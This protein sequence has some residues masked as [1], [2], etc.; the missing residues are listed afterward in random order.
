MNGRIPVLLFE[1]YKGENEKERE[2]RTVIEKA[3][4]NFFCVL[5]VN[6]IRRTCNDKR[7]LLIEEWRNQN[8]YEKIKYQNQI[9]EFIYKIGL[10]E[11]CAPFNLVIPD[12]ITIKL[13]DTGNK[14][15]Y[16][17]IETIISKK[18][19]IYAVLDKMKYYD[20]IIECSEIGLTL[21]EATYHELIHSCGEFCCDGIIRYNW[22]GIDVIVDLLK[23]KGIVIKKPGRVFILGQHPVKTCDDV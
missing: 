2:F 18:P 6:N 15:M 5:G 21:E 9:T 7:K 13:Q 14:H 20:D 16:I 22:I 4:Y 17:P 23:K 1:Q 19:I 11:L 8:P 12:T 10:C 3:F